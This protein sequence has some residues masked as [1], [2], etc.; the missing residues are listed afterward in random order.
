MPGFPLNVVQAA[1]SGVPIIV[2]GSGAMSARAEPAGEATRT[3]AITT[4][5]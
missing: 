3:E 1:P 4:S 2:H 5:R